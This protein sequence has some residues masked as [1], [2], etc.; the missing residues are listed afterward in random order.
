MKFKLNLNQRPNLDYMVDVEFDKGRIEQWS[1]IASYK[2]DVANPFNAVRV[3]ILGEFMGASLPF[4]VDQAK[5]TENIE[6]MG[7][8]FTPH[9]LQFWPQYVEQPTNIQMMPKL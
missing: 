6:A 9:G 7:Q 5:M 1:V 4:G 2:L 8:I 3:G